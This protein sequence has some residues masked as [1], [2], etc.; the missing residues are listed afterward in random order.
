MS[1]FF[2]ITTDGTRRYHWA[3]TIKQAK[4]DGV[5]WINLAQNR[6]K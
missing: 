2:H 4:C 1:N 5:E 3:T 6:D